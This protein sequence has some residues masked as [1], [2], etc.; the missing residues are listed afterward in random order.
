MN[1]T[2]HELSYLVH[3]SRMNAAVEAEEMNLV[4]SE[5]KSMSKWENCDH[6]WR[7][8]VDSQHH[9]ESATDVVCVKCD[10]PGEK[11]SKTGDVHWPAS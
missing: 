5:A 6:E 1:T 11:N 3:Q 10:C 2:E 4:A 8:K 7:E 9:S